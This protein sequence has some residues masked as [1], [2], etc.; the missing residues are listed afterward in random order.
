MSE[1]LNI[2]QRINKIRESVGY[3]KKDQKVQGY[4]AVTHDAV[5]SAVR[6]YLIKYGVVIVPRLDSSQYIDTGTTT[7]NGTPWM[8]YE[9]K[10]LIDFVNIDEPADLITVPIESHALDTGDKAPGKAASYATKYAMLKLFSI[11]TGENEEGRQEMKP[12]GKMTGA[13][14]DMAR[15]KKAVNYIKTQIDED[16]PDSAPANLQKAWSK[17][18]NDERL[19]VQEW[20]T[21]KAPDTNRMY[22]TL[23]K[24]YLNHKEEVA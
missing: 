6:E 23:L 4:N 19:E 16:D 22:K 1:K 2:Y 15:V 10:Y 24:D 5:T 7:G 3:I 11:E 8:R 13:D 9:A 17:L 20:L 12:R 18:S 14:I 21:D